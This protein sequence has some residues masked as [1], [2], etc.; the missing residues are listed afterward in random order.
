VARV[1]RGALRPDQRDVARAAGRARGEYG[2]VRSFPDRDR[3]PGALPSAGHR[4]LRV[5][6]SRQIPQAKATLARV[7]IQAL[8]TLAEPYARHELHT[9]AWR[10]AERGVA[11]DDELALVATPAP[12]TRTGILAALPASAQRP[13]QRQMAGLGR[14]LRRFPAFHQPVPGKW[15]LGRTN[16]QITAPPWA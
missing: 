8:Q 5:P 1:A 10:D 6:Q 4:D 13:H 3:V 7:G 11:G 2:V 9:L 15:Q 12:M 14:L 16:M